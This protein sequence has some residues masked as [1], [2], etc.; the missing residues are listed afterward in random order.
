MIT[1]KIKYFRAMIVF[2]LISILLVSFVF[3]NIA[4]ASSETVTA[5]A[6]SSDNIA[7][8]VEAT[9]M[10]NYIKKLTEAGNDKEI[11]IAVL[12]TGINP[13]HEVFEGRLDLNPAYARDYINNDDTIEDVDGHG[14]AIA[15]LIAESTPSNVKIIPVKVIN[16]EA[17]L[18]KSLDFVYNGMKAVAYEAD[19]LCFALGIEPAGV[20]PI[21]LNA[22]T[23]TLTNDIPE[24]T[25]I[26]S[27]V[28][29]YIDGSG[30]QEVQA[31]ALLSMFFNATALDEENNI[32]E[33]SRYGSRVDFALP[34][35]NLKVA[36]NASNTGYRTVSGT[37][38]SA[39]LLSG[40]FGLLKAEFPDY[41]NEQL[42]EILIENC[43][44]LGDAGKDDYY[45]YGKIN[46]NTSMF[47]K[48]NIVNRT[49]NE[50]SVGFSPSDLSDSNFSVINP[51][52]NT[53]YVSCEAPCLVVTKEIG[54]NNYTKLVA[55]AT[56][57]QNV[58]SFSLNI[59]SST[60]VMILLKGDID[61]NGIVTVR[62]LLK[63]RDAVLADEVD[64]LEELDTLIYNVD[65]RGIIGIS[66]I[67]TLRNEILTTGSIAW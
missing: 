41:T 62:D 48:V 23:E 60:E 26:V 22:L 55:T 1:N 57:V 21:Q 28:G 5:L 63:L 51:S 37:A 32:M 44:D 29:D 4:I 16:T 33:Y 47:K 45:G 30:T 56:E 25:V 64:D 39:G 66:D 43:E 18:F 40:A 12:D 31:P 9:G 50:A 6:V 61:R 54:K 14:T 19:I 65:G 2:S 10:D 42:K 17:E 59:S 20:S 13:N 46:F 52:L 3:H 15:S 24:T 8:G 49:Q 53:F 67:V 11:K 34:G 38:Y 35:V 27:N 58:Y 36:S 7:W